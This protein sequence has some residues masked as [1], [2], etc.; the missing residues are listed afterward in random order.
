MEFKMSS[1]LSV[2]EK[3]GKFVVARNNQPIVIPKNEAET[4]VTEFDTQSDAE[5]YMSILKHLE[6]KKSS[7]SCS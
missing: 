3:N 2:I 5:K 4:I 1:D 6:K 7:K